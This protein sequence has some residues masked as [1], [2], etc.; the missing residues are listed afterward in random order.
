[1]RNLF[2]L[3]D[4]QMARLQPL[5][6]KSHG[7]PRVDDRRVLSRISSSI[8]MACGGAMPL[9]SMVRRRPYTTDGSGGGTRATL[10]R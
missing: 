2:W 3:T 7:M 8:A 5:F 9:R 10:P 4:V 1:M 6:P